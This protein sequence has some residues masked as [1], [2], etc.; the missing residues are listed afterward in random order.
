MQTDNKTQIQILS[1]V[2]KSVFEKHNIDGNALLKV[3]FKQTITNKYHAHS[4]P[5]MSM[6]ITTQ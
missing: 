2:L 6:S 3:E 5:K 1:N 4:Y